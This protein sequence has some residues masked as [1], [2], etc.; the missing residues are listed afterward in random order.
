MNR[1]I[2]VAMPHINSDPWRGPATYDRWR[3]GSWGTALLRQKN[4]PSATAQTY[5]V[6]LCYFIHTPI[7]PILYANS[8]GPAS[9]ITAFPFSHFPD[10]STIERERDIHTQERHE[11]GEQTDRRF[12]R[13]NALG[14]FSEATAVKLNQNPLV[15]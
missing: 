11:A 13:P 8:S 2:L 4:Q 10:A 9:A 3:E 6:L 7:V 5:K 1:T 14:W 15:C 12:E